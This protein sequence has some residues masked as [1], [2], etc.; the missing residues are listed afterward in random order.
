MENR[1][2]SGVNA[3]WVVNEEDTVSEQD[4]RK[5]DGAFAFLIG[6]QARVVPAYVR[7]KHLTTVSW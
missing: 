2:A 1:I 6:G 4:E 5:H 3:L 7:R